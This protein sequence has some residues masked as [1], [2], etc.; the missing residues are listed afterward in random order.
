[1]NAGPLN[2]ADADLKG[3]DALDSGRY[4]AEVFNIKMDAT[5]GG[6]GAKTPAGTPLMKVQIKVL[7]PK[8]GGE[9][10]DQDRRV[11]TQFVIPPKGYDPK[12]SA[13]MNGMIARF[14]IATGD[15][16]EM[17]RSKGFDPDWEDYKGRPLVVT[18]SKVQKYG[19]KPDDNE[20]E[21]KVT[22]FKPAGSN[23]GGNSG[24]L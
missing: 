15:T 19:T 21:N 11:F 8:I 2:L 12:K 22:G 5:K 17:I 14:L 13:T 6:E 24:L 4:D 23:T 10:I 20:W 1:M 18:L 9:V 3:F 16:E 7:N